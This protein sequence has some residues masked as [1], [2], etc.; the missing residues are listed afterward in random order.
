MWDQTGIPLG[1]PS[2]D[3]KADIA[4]T[5]LQQG[6]QT[7]PQHWLQVLGGIAQSATGAY[8][9]NQASKDDE[10]SFQ[11]ALA[12]FL[13]P[14]APGNQPVDPSLSPERPSGPGTTPT[15]PGTTPQSPYNLAALAQLGPK[16]RNFALQQMLR[17]QEKQDDRSWTEKRD[18]KGFDRDKEML[19][20]KEDLQAQ[21]EA[22][23]RAN[24]QSELQRLHGMLTTEVRAGRM[25][26]DEATE[27]YQNKVRE[28]KGQ[29][30]FEPKSDV[31]KEAYDLNEIAN[32]W[33][34]DSQQYKDAQAKIAAK[35]QK[36]ITMGEDKARDDW[37]VDTK[38]YVTTRN[39][40]DRIRGAKQDAVGDLVTIYSFMRSLDPTSTV[41]EGEFATAQ[42]TAGVDDRIRNLYNRVLSG[43]RL[44]PE[45]RKGFSE[46]SEI[47][48]QKA[49]QRYRQTEK[50]Y[51]D[52]AKTRGWNHRNFIID[53][54]GNPQK[55]PG[56][57]R[58]DAQGNRIQ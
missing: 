52:L 15:M 27:I 51:Q 33:G 12:A 44:T 28:L 43:V 31:G 19:R 24:Q 57:I 26:A 30:P 53:Y 3:W 55:T 5:L 23:A 36:D 8:M 17:Q 42:N 25:K 38:D 14:N 39:M 49:E 4:R 46:Q 50:Q 41:R 21:R 9:Q 54:S 10:Q 6:Q 1:E 32:R 58:Y 35:G 34:K 47:I 20:Y 40:V 37:R 18:E 29:R 16:Y 7:K 48:M 2:G 11:K 13:Q 56:R 45:Q 22:R